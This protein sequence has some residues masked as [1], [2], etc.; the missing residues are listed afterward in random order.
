M[1]GILVDVRNGRYVAGNRLATVVHHLMH[2]HLVDASVCGNHSAAGVGWSSGGEALHGVGLQNE[3]M[4]PC[5]PGEAGSS[6]GG[7]LEELSLCVVEDGLCNLLGGRVLWSM[8]GL[9]A[10]NAH[11]T[12]RTARFASCH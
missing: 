10:A 8:W 1:G 11:A 2:P 12:R 3:G 9:R 4:W 7:L 6:Q 5:C